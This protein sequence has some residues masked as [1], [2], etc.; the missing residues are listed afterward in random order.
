VNEGEKEF[1]R[2]L[3]KAR[4]RKFFAELRPQWRLRPVAVASVVLVVAI[5]VVVAISPPPRFRGFV[6]GQPI[7][8]FIPPSKTSAPSPLVAVKLENGDVLSVTL[9]R[10]VIA[11]PGARM[12][13]AIYER[14]FG[15]LHQ[16]IVKFDS[17][18]DPAS[19]IDPDG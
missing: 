1:D 11:R 13:V 10:G 5:L 9:P 12:K 8:E 6:F 7:S 16:E 14:G 15:P 17:Y 18:I 4:R 2:Q 3:R 19:G